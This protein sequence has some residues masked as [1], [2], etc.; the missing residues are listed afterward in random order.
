MHCLPFSFLGISVRSLISQRHR[1]SCCMIA[2]FVSKKY[3]VPIGHGNS[4][5]GHGKVVE[6][7]WKIIVEKQWSP[8][9]R[10]VTEFKFES[11]CCRTPT[12]FG[13]SKIRQIFGLVP[14]HYLFW[15]VQVHHSSQSNV[16]NTKVNRYT[17][18]SYLLMSAQTKRRIGLELLV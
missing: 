13:K 14:I 2:Y 1:V 5:F 8:C 6:K 17:L 18:N 15:K 7:S 11:E 16:R 9:S 3:A 10:D 12:V 4:F